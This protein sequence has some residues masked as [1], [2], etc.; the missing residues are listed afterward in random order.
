MIVHCA[1]TEMVPIGDLIEHPM[2]PNK[3]P[4]VQLKYLAKILAHQGWRHPITVSKRSGY[5]V[6]GHGRLQ[7]A[8]LNGWLTAPVDRQEFLSEADEY[9][10]LIAD[11][12]IAELATHDDEMMRMTIENSFADMDFDLLGIP[13][14][15][16]EEVLPAE[17]EVAEVKEQWI[18]SIECM[19]ETQLQGLFSEMS[20]RGLLCKI[21]T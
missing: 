17:P 7:A 3:H 5:I 16:L 9:A 2:N 19:S 6:A 11:N 12:K 1:H 18:L 15:S 8:K 20:E 4:E 13:D 14:F 10:H 21:I